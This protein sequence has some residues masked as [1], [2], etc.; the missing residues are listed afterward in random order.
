MQGG[1]SSSRFANIPILASTSFPAST[2]AHVHNPRRLAQQYSLLDPELLGDHF[3]IENNHRSTHHALLCN[4]GAAGTGQ[5]VTSLPSTDGV[6]PHD[7]GLENGYGA[8]PY[9]ERWV[10]AS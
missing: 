9:G 3:T 4:T 6:G 8:S 2:A 10:G 7:E 1:I 5:H